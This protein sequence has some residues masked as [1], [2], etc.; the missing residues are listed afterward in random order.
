MFEK[1]RGKRFLASVM[2]LVMMLSLAPVGALATE[3]EGPPAEHQA[4][5]QPAVTDEEDTTN[6]SIQTYDSYSRGQASISVSIKETKREECDVYYAET[7]T[8]S[9]QNTSTDTTLKVFDED[10]Q[11][12]YSDSD[13]LVKY[14]VVFFV[15]PHDGYALK[16]LNA[17]GSASIYNSIVDNS[18]I[19]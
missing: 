16:Y 3:D 2:A 13:K 19:Y 1:K 18:D 9:R 8:K 14:G 7:F 5:A 15:K 17:S 6:T 11:I 10:G 12:T 4:V